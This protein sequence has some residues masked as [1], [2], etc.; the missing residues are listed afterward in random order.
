MLIFQ[1]GAAALGAIVAAETAQA[2][3]SQRLL[4]LAGRYARYEISDAEFYERTAGYSADRVAQ[5]LGVPVSA[6]LTA[7]GMPTA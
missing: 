6:V 5:A 2:H 3:A 1:A 7:R 4:D